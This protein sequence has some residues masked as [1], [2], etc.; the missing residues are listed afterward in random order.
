MS[1]EVYTGDVCYLDGWHH[2][3]AKD[4]L[5]NDV[6]GVRLVLD[7]DGVYVL[8][9]DGDESWH[10]RKH[11]QFTL[12]VPEDGGTSVAVTADE[13]REIQAVLEARRGS[14]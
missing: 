14:E 5:G 9:E 3:V 6:P 11:R 1:A 2:T 12:V 4:E 10:E 13:M 8:A 7:D